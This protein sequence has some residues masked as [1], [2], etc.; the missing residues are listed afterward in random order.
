MD[1]TN[2]GQNASRTGGEILVDGLLAQGATTI[3]GVPGESFLAVLDAI[4]DR[5]DRIRFVNCRQEGGAAFMADAYAKMTGKPGLCLVTRGPGACN[6]SIGLHTAWQ[7]STP[8][9][10]MIGQIPRDHKEREAFQEVEYKYMFAPFAKWICEV[11]SPERL[12]EH[13]SHAF[14]MAQAGR[15]G[16]VVLVLPEDVLTAHA[17]AEDLP[18]AIVAKPAPREE[19]LD[20]ICKA[21]NAA[22]RPLCILGGPGWTKEAKRAF[23]N[24]TENNGVPVVTSLRCQDYFDNAHSCYVG[25]LGI[26]ANADVVARVRE[27]DLLL[28]IGARLGEMTTQGYTMPEPPR[29]R[30]FLIHVHPDANELGRVYY[31]DLPVV[32]NTSAFAECISGRKAAPAQERLDWTSSARESYETLL[33]PPKQPGPLDMGL[34]LDALRKRLPEDAIITNGAGNY[35]TWIHKFMQFRHFRS[36]LAPTSGAMGYGIPAAAAAKIAEP[37]RK[38]VSFAGDGCFQM[39]GQ[40]LGVMMQYGLDP[41]IIV[42][43]NSIYGTIRMH[44]EREYPEHVYGTN[45][46]NPDFTALAAAYGF[47]SE[48]LAR[49]EDIDA[50]LDRAMAA[51]GAALIEC[52]IDPEGIS[53]RMTISSLRKMALERQGR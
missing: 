28:V 14:H 37:A 19:E 31:A 23:E 46:T 1:R 49:S 25:D 51:K 11:D 32:A 40:E 41:L 26:S 2:T 16:P 9:V 5:S 18:A 13:L 39:N 38:V 50:V 20:R 24:F 53:P 10:V 27:A 45:L 17:V 29:S 8:M 47:H 52:R 7:D 48:V 33:T 44:Q 36:Q 43:N 6:A 21:L 3:F 34:V 42:V 15:P 30:Q 12:P 22:K 35:A 4:H